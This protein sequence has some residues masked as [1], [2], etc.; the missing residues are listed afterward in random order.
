M[1][2]GETDNP[3]H[4][5]ALSYMD[6]NWEEEFD[7]REDASDYFSKLK[8]YSETLGVSPDQRKDFVQEKAYDE[9]S[10]EKVDSWIEE[11][12]S[13]SEAVSYAWNKLE[14]RGIDPNSEWDRHVETLL[15]W[16]LDNDHKGRSK[17]FYSD[18]FQE[19]EYGTHL[20]WDFESDEKDPAIVY[21]GEMV[22]LPNQ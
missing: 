7:S 19:S 8:L 13:I 18:S 3:A 21:D 5:D 10:A 16:E 9:L 6:D 4:A 12:G 2:L 20:I 1:F 11:F 15:D 17:Q 22:D 14:Q